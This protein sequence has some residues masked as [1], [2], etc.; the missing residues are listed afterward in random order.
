MSK[1]ATCDVTMS[2]F[3]TNWSKFATPL[4]KS[5][6]FRVNV[7]IQKWWHVAGGI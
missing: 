2:K 7:V 5:V 6:A 4:D 3:A 1:F